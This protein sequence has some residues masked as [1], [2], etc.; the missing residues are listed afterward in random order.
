[1]SHPKVD[2]PIPFP[3]PISLR[4]CSFSKN[5]IKICIASVF[6]IGSIVA[7]FLS[8]QNAGTWGKKT[9]IGIMSGG[10][11]TALVS[12][13]VLCRAC[14]TRDKKIADR[15]VRSLFR[16]NQDGCDGTVD[17][18]DAR[19]IVAELNKRRPPGIVFNEATIASSLKGGTCTAMALTFLDAYFKG[20]KEWEKEGISLT[21]GVASLG[22]QFSSSSARMRVEQAAYDTIE[23]CDPL[24]ENISKSK[25]EAL[26]GYHSFAVTAV[27][28]EMDVRVLKQPSEIF[29]V[30]DGA[31]LLR[32]LKPADNIKFEEHGHSLVYIQEQ[33][34]CLFYDSNNG[35][36]SIPPAECKKYLFNSFKQC[37]KE[38][39]ITKATFYELRPEFV[40]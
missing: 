16:G 32:I 24:L 2:I 10:S 36:C 21:K 7:F 23:V 33:G 22:S 37:L 28:K 4:P 3:L 31:Y 35:V 34:V 14:Y 38:F 25:V 11:A 5:Q 20:R 8:I 13:I 30:E 19:K 27:S 18:S 9:V 1:M 15:E 6:L 39:E 29:D 26:A 12:I 17:I 40:L